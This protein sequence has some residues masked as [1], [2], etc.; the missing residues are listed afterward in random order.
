MNP[1]MAHVLIVVCALALAVSSCDSPTGPT[2]QAPE[3]ATEQPDDTPQR[4][5]DETHDAPTLWQPARLHVYTFA[6]ELSRD[7]M[8]GEHVRD[9]WQFSEDTYTDMLRRVRATVDSHNRNNPDDLL[10]LLGGG[11]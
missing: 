5:Y 10:Q 3:Q 6:A 11:L 8:S 1:R 7:E 4:D 2:E 9:E